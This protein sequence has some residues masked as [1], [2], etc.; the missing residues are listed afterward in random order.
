MTLS[1]SIL[2]LSS[3]KPLNQSISSKSLH[4]S[5]FSQSLIWPP[6]SFSSSSSSHQVRIP[7]LTSCIAVASHSLASQIWILRTRASWVASSLVRPYKHH[8]LLIYLYQ[9]RILLHLRPLQ[10]IHKSRPLSLFISHSSSP[11]FPINVI[12]PAKA[13]CDGVTARRFLSPTTVIQ[14][15]VMAILD[16][17]TR[18]FMVQRLF[19]I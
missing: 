10:P 17:A 6:F 8:V 12:D 15:G 1:L 4:A 2:S 9:H 19:K 5:L 14:Y 7:K 16:G 11:F 18:F 13:V 3:L